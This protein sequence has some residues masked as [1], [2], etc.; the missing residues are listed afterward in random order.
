MA[1]ETANVA[2][3]ANKVSKEILEWFKWEKIPLMDENFKCHKP[4]QH[5]TKL[6]K[7]TPP[8]HKLLPS[9]CVPMQ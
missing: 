1:G 9:I 4:E 7:N 6:P 3:V 5:K 8:A 2:E